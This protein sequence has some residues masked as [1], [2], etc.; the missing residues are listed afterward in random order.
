MRSTCRKEDLLGSVGSTLARLPPKKKTYLPRSTPTN[1]GYTKPKRKTGN[2]TFREMSDK[3][4]ESLKAQNKCLICKQ[5]GH[6]A[7]DCPNKGSVSTAYQQVSYNQKPW[8]QRTPFQGSRPW[9]SRAA[10]DVMRPPSDNRKYLIPQTAKVSCIALVQINGKDAQVLID[11]CTI[12]GN[13]ISNQF[14]HMY[15]IPTE[16]TE[17][18]ILETAVRGS[19]SYINSKATVEVEIQG[20]KETIVF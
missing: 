17:Q 2:R 20:H 3:E 6:Y 4:K 11:P 14:C 8:Q 15:K 16:Q 7:R 1:T 13:L 19:K 12:H 10:L 9:S 18:K 5:V